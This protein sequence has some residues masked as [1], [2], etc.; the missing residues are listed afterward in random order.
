MFCRPYV[1]PSAETVVTSDTMIVCTARVK[2]MSH[3]V[4][5]RSAGNATAAPT[6]AAPS[7]PASMASKAPTCAFSTR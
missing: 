6:S 1:P 7:V 4:V 2:R 3:S 5:S